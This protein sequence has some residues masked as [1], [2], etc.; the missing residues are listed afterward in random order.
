MNKTIIVILACLLFTG[1]AGA[2]ADCNLWNSMTPEH[3]ADYV[4]NQPSEMKNKVIQKEIIK[5]Q[6]SKIFKIGLEV[7]S[8]VSIPW[9]L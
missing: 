9:G 4:W 6:T 5:D 1:C 3:Y 7:L 8:T 2:R